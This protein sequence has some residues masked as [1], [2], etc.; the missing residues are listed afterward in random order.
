M[1]GEGEF[2]KADGDIFF[3][4]EA[5]RFARAGGF[6]AAGSVTN[7][8]INVGSSTDGIVN[9]SFVIAVNILDENSL[10]TLDCHSNAS[11]SAGVG[12]FEVQVSG[13]DFGIDKRIGSHPGLNSFNSFNMRG[14]LGG[15]R[16]Y[17][18]GTQINELG[19]TKFTSSPNGQFTSFPNSGLVIFLITRHSN[20]GANKG[21]SQVNIQFGR[22]SV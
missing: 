4:S 7:A 14:I 5:N 20:D 12:H 16:S 22:S 13:T 6:L 1:A 10:I 18:N 2:N 8:F 19:L 17:L 3:A 21:P 15:G 11:F 9:G